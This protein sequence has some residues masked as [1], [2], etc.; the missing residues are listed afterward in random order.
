VILL[1]PFERQ[2]YRGADGFVELGKSQQLGHRRCL[3]RPSSYVPLL[4]AVAT[5][6]H[7]VAT[8]GMAPHC[9]VR[10]QECL[11]YQ[12][13]LCQDL[14]HGWR[15]LELL[16]IEQQVFPCEPKAQRQ[17]HPIERELGSRKHVWYRLLILIIPLRI[18][19][20]VG[21]RDQKS[22]GR[23]RT[24]SRWVFVVHQTFQKRRLRARE[25]SDQTLV[26]QTSYLQQ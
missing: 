17:T 26:C 11:N 10:T 24:F 3:Q 16:F 12:V 23:I 19:D 7:Q 15:T 2:R 6:V 8:F 5:G 14:L 25:C 18:R 1:L 13:L 22:V 4:L 21:Y 9:F 20:R